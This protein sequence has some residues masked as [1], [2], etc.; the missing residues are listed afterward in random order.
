MQKLKSTEK[1]NE[2]IKESFV[3]PQLIFKHSNRCSIS[4]MAHSRM[5]PFEGRPATYIIDVVADRSLSQEIARVFGVV[6]QSPQ[7][8]VIKDGKCVYD[9]SH[10]GISAPEVERQ[11]T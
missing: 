9:H 6:H 5:R 2:I 4:A 3:H 7:V 8:L 11:L 1:L 10:M